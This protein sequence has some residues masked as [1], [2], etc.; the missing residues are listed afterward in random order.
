MNIERPFLLNALRQGLKQSPVVSLLG[1][2]QVGK[3]TLARTL[4]KAQRS[5]IFDLED[6]SDLEAL[7]TPKTMLSPL[8]GLVVL[9][10]VQRLPTLFPLLRVLADRQPL[11][12]RFLLL[13]SADPSLIKGV[14][15]SLAG[16]VRHI[17]MGGFTL[18][19]SKGKLRRLWLRGGFPRSFLAK[20]EADSLAWREDFIRTFLERDIPQLDLHIPAIVLRR[21]WTMLAHYHGQTFNGSEIAA[22]LGLSQP[23]VR[24]YLDIL[25]GAFMVRQLPAFHLNLGKRL[26]RAPKVYIRDSGL[27]GALLG[28]ASERDLLSHP[29]AGASWEGFALEQVITLVGE[30]RATFWRTQ[31][32]AEL[33]LH[34]QAQGKAFGFEFKLSDAPS[35]TASMRIA[36]KDLGLK[37]LW[38]V[39]PGSKRYQLAEGIE[40]LPLE[41]LASVAKFF[42]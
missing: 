6:P 16:R 20:G 17:D 23:T 7:Q 41:D 1:P 4:A 19:E 32:G 29:K 33:D 24:R 38:V 35:L 15:E 21:F 14:S 26:V 37:H 3:S 39:Y 2:R 5:A 36:K 13:G 30:R 9:D 10:E 22:A 18:D 11:P 27:F 40:A 34:V 31:H 8:K 42:T 28:I 12:A 25:T